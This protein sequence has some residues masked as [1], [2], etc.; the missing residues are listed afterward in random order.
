MALEVKYQKLRLRLF[1][2]DISPKIVVCENNDPHSVKDKSCLFDDK[3]TI[4]AEIKRIS[5]ILER[6]IKYL[7]KVL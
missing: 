4:E 1:E 3:A 2:P 7:I 6:N 5:G